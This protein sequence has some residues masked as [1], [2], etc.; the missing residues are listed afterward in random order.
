MH[1]TYI[2][3]S[4]LISSNYIYV[5][6]VCKSHNKNEITNNDGNK[7]EVIAFNKNIQKYNKLL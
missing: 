4:K 7:L 6:K 2:S 3:S 5:H 1:V